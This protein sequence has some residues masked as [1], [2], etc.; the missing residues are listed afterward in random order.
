MC[1][2]GVCSRFLVAFLEEMVD[3]A[4]ETH[5]VGRGLVAYCLGGEEIGGG[6]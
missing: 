2:G 1:W 3:G 4:V 6:E 5:F